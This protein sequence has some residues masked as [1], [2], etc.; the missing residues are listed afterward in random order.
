MRKTKIIIYALIVFLLLPSIIFAETQEMKEYKVVKGDT[1][2]DI[3]HTE[4]NDPFRWPEVWK[5]NPW[6]KNP[7][8]IYP[9]QIIKI[10]LYLF[11]KEKIN[12][13]AA[14][15]SEVLFPESAIEG[16]AA[17]KPEVLSPASAIEGPAAPEPAVASAEPTK[18]EVK[19]ETAK[20]MK[21][22][23]VDKNLLIA[24]GY[25]ADTIPGVGH[26][27][28]PASGE[29]TFGNGDIVYVSIDHPAKAGDKF[30]VIKAS[31]L[32]EHPITGKDIGYVITIDGIAEVLKIKNGETTAKITKCFREIDRGDRLVSYY[33]IEPPMTT[34]HFRSPDIKGA[35]V[36]TANNIALQ[37]MFDIIYID[38]G[39]KD[40][41][42]AGDM[43][44][45]FAV[46]AHTV[47]NGL[48]QVINCRDHTATAII[49]QSI[50]PIS[51]G[52]IFTKLDKN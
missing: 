51:P 19:K 43:F 30:Y 25:I 40:G 20:I 28:R 21:Q 39:C 47:Q 46:N 12:K 34:G 18:A 22:P 36:A 17:P 45:T 4:L 10:P 16:P 23:L 52:N 48:I 35:I 44:M 5:V 33:D 15:K 11:Q 49:T 29:N 7:H 26:V 1:L 38:K 32:I 3:T 31:E 24:S 2:W 37:S 8:W 9:Q 13:E 27:D 50:S 6:I 41:I 14:P 42:E